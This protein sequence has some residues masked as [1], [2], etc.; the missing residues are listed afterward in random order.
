M[1]TLD[2]GQ[3]RF[4][5]DGYFNAMPQEMMEKIKQ[6]C[7]QGLN[8]KKQGFQGDAYLEQLE[9]N[10]IYLA[11]ASA[12]IQL[13]I[14]RYLSFGEP[15]LPQA[16]IAGYVK[17]VRENS[18]S[19]AQEIT[20]QILNY[21]RNVADEYDTNKQLS[22]QNWSKARE[23]RLTGNMAKYIDELEFSYVFFQATYVLSQNFLF[24]FLNDVELA[25]CTTAIAPQ[26]VIQTI[27]QRVDIWA[28]FCLG[29]IQLRGIEN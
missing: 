25:A 4:I 13:A 17:A 14:A 11:E 21:I 7:L 28:S 10:T 1:A 9:K 20:L 18:I 26:E 2:L 12:A 16:N 22:N 8:D 3:V 15:R 24:G 23:L 6:G 5:F 27:R 19:P 29:N